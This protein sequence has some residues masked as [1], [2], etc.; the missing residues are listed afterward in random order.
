MKYILNQ[1]IPHQ[2]YFED[3]S[4]IP[5]APCEE[6]VLSDYIANFAKDLGLEIIQDDK[7]NLIVYKSASKGY[8]SHPT[9]LIQSHLDMVCEKNSESNHD[10]SKDPLKLYV[11]NGYVSALGTTLGADD[12]YGVAYMMAI[13]A[14]KD[15]KHPPLECI[16]TVQE[17]IG[18]LG[19]QKLKAEYFNGRKLIN[20]DNGSNLY[21]Y[22]SCA[23][24]IRSVITKDLV[25]ENCDFPVYKLAIKGL[26]GGHS[27]GAIHL[28]RGNSNKIAS[29]ILYHLNKKYGINIVEI[30]GGLQ[31]N[32]IPR[33]CTAIFVCNN[34]LENIKDFVKEQKTIIQKELQYSDSGMEIT[35]DVCK[36]SKMCNK[37]ISDQIV[38]LL[39][40]LPNGFQHKNIYLDVTSA[41]ENMGVI[42]SNEHQLKCEYTFRGALDSYLDEMEEKVI[43]FCEI[44]DCDYERISRHPTWEYNPSSQMRDVLSSVYKEFYKIDIIE[45]ATHGS[46]ECGV[47]KKF[48]PDMD[49]V[50]IGPE[51]FDAHTT[52]ERMNIQSFDDTYSLLVKYLERL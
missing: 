11:Q 40:L 35:L 42:R 22:V 8:E 31:D 41:S 10:F 51:C 33:E 29:R 46:L 5:H 17:E 4:M 26:Y 45:K 20:L 50:T 36:S 9:I 2:K 47:F 23:G 16:F 14:D 39:Y 32:A 25:M 24:G 1:M 37:K 3:I 15:L 21:T 7:S 49:I 28:E 38:N 48:F 52:T 30:N 44:F 43:T 13:L 12:G 34:M 18:L 27:G 6:K 19:V